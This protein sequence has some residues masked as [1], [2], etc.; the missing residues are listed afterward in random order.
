[1]AG[2]LVLIQETT[3][4]SATASVT[5]T[6]IDSTFDVYTVYFSNVECTNDNEEFF[7]RVTTGGTPD[8][9]S[10]YDYAMKELKSY[11]D[12]SDSGSTNGTQQYITYLGTPTQEQANGILYLFNFANSSE[13]S[14]Y[15]I[16]NLNLNSISKLSGA[17]GSG[18]HTVEEANDGISF[19]MDN[20]NI[21][22]GTFSL[23]GLKK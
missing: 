21:D 6:G 18:V 17:Q 4:S 12:F 2:S 14:F 1:M 8:S 19:F 3:V 10:Q 11:G 5:L 9:D 7:F 13:Y 23:Y 15:T 16:E 22:S 20:G